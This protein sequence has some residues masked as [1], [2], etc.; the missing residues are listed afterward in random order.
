VVLRTHSEEEC[1]LLR[2][3]ALGTVFFGEDELAKGM[4]GHVLARFDRPAARV[5]AGA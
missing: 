1:K 4:S 5:E 2:R 3:E